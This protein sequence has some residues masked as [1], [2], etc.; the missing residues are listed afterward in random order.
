MFYEE[1]QWNIIKREVEHINLSAFVTLVLVFNIDIRYLSRYS[2][3]EDDNKF[4]R[5][6]AH[7]ICFHYE[8][9]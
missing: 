6:G 9:L 1:E 4:F 3:I 5:A 2:K 8:S 7:K